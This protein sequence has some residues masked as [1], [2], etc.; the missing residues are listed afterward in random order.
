MQPGSYLCV[1]AFVD[2][3]GCFCGKEM[4]IQTKHAIPVHTSHPGCLQIKIDHH[5]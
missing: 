5:K 1:V 2:L 4:A 3:R